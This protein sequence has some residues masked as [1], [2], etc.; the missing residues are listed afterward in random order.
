MKIP[1]STTFMVLT[2]FVT[3]AKTLGKTIMK[4]VSGYGLSFALALIIYLPFCKFIQNYCTTIRGTDKHK[5]FWTPF[6]WITTGILWSVWLM[7]DMSNIAVFLPRNLHWGELIAVLI[8][9]T[10]G[11]AL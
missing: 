4:S 11:L 6:Q 7:Q 8:V 5:L 9:T 1:V 10:V 2:V 3:K